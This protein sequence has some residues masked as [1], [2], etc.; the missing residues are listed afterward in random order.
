MLTAN[1]QINLCKSHGEAKVTLEH[2]L[3]ERD[4][5]LEVNPIQPQ[6][7]SPDASSIGSAKMGKGHHFG[8]QRRALEHEM[9]TFPHHCMDPWACEVEAIFVAE[10]LNTIERYFFKLLNQT[11]LKPD[12]ILS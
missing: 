5:R 7:P 12:Y 2:H 11:R 1:P 6:A 8:G 9:S 10:R 3:Q 4:F